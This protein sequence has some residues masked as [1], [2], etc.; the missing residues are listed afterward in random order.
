MRCRAHYLLIAV[1]TLSGMGQMIVACGQ[2]GDLYLP[3]PEPAQQT[4]A[5]TETKAVRQ[6][7]ADG[8]AAAEAGPAAASEARQ[9]GSEP[10]QQTMAGAEADAVRQVA[11]EDES[12]VKAG[13]TAASGVEQPEQE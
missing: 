4:T 3:E 11:T 9:P 1:I 10:A 2:K 6:A 7:K 12:A 13:P 8:K 5:G